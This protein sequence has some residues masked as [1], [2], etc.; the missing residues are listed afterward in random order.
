[1]NRTDAPAKQGVPFGVNGNRNP[2]GA[3][4]PAGDNSASYDVGFPPITM[5]LKSAGGLPPKG[6]D[7]NEILYELSALARWGST[8]AINRFDPSFASAIGGYP[9]D[10]QV[11]S[12]DGN[13]I[14]RSLVDNN[15][16]NPNSNSSGWVATPS[17]PYPVGAPIP[18]PVAAPPSGFLAMTG[19][20][21][22]ASTYPLLAIAYPSLILPDLRAEFIR[23]WDGDRGIDAGRVLLSSQADSIGPHIHNAKATQ[24]LISSGSSNY[25]LPVGSSVG[26][27]SPTGTNEPLGVETRPRNITFNYIVRA[28]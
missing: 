8:G 27:P 12:N 20:S 23:G 6:Q 25:L 28:A 4:T 16:N 9:Q 2:I 5:I 10:A 22:S 7:M 24:G 21:F 17:N 15:A 3:T 1:M 13:I 11:L 26:T 19:Q 14:W 18:W